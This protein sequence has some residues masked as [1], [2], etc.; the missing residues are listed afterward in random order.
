MHPPPPEP[1]HVISY[2]EAAAVTVPARVWRFTV[3]NRHATIPL[4]VPFGLLAAGVAVHAEHLGFDLLVIGA[5][6]TVVMYVLAPYKW[7]RG[8]EVTYARATVAALSLWLTIA[9]F[10][11]VSGPLE[12]ALGVGCA[13]WGG[14]FWWHTPPRP[15]S[16][17]GT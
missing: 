10:A 8:N 17:P 3:R 7:D 4:A 13:V 15:Q 16:P 2:S 1:H 11:G 12:V 9:A 6:G 5:A 14:L